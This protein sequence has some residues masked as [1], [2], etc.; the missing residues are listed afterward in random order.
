MTAYKKFV[1]TAA[2]AALVAT[3]VTPA[4]AASKF[5]D[6]STYSADV[7]KEINDLAAAKIINGT[8]ETTFSPAR[9]ITRGQVVKLLGR[10]LVNEGYAKVPADWKTKQRFSDIAVNAT[11]QDL[12]KNAAVVF[13][14]KVFLGSNGKLMSTGKISR[15]NMA[16]VLDRAAKAIN[17]TSF[18]EVVKDE[19]LK[20]N[21]KDLNN[22]KK[23]AREAIAALNALG[24]SNVATFNP[25][26]NVTRA[27]FVSFLH[28]AFYKDASALTIK[29]V[30][31][32]SATELTV[33]LSDTTVHQIKLNSKLPENKE[34]EIRIVVGGKEYKVKVKYVPLAVKSV[35]AKSATELEVVLNDDTKHTVTL[36]EALPEN[37]EQEV[38]FKIDNKEYKVKVKYVPL[39]V[40]SAVAKSATE[41]EVV[42]SDDTKHTVK[43][44][45]A[46]PQNEE[47]EVTFKIANKEYKAKVTYVVEALN[48]LAVTAK[49][50]AQL[51]VKFNQAVK[52][53]G[54]V[55]LR[56][57]DVVDE[58][59]QATVNMSADGKTALVTADTELNG[60]Y[61]VV[62][63]NFKTAAGKVN[64]KYDDVVTVAEDKT[65]PTI[66]G[67]ER[68]F[69]SRVIV[70]FSEPLKTMGKVTVTLSDGKVVNAVP[71]LNGSQVIFDLKDT[72]IPVNTDLLAT[73]VGAADVAGNLISP[74]P[75]NI[76]FQ[77]GKAD[78][79]APAISAVTQTGA[80]TF[81]VQFS[82]AV[83]ALEAKQVNVSKAAVANAVQSVERIS[84]T[85]YKVT[86]ASVL[87]GLTTIA[88]KDVTDLSGEVTTSA[89]TTKTFEVDKVAPKVTSTAVVVKDGQQYLDVNFD[90]NVT[91]DAAKVAVK[92]TYLK[93]GVTYTVDTK[94]K[95]VL[96]AAV[97]NDTVRI[98]L[99]D[100]A[101][102]QANYTVALAFTGITNEA[103]TAAEA[104]ENVTFT[105][106]EDVIENTTKVTVSKIE[107]S[108][109]NNNQIDVTFSHDVDALTATNITNYQIDGVTIEKAVVLSSDL[110]KVTLTLAKDSVKNTGERYIDI[111]NVKAVNSTVAMDAYQQKLDLTE[112]VTP[113]V[114]GIEL[115][116]DNKLELTFTEAV[117]GLTEQSFNVAAGTVAFDGVKTTAEA[118]GATKATVTLKEGDSFKSGTTV[119]VTLNASEAGSVKDSNGNVLDVAQQIL[120]K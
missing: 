77:K 70:T 111:K 87:D 3:A 17:G 109:T 106:G 15:E 69:A 78:G 102:E 73:F 115:V 6:I 51:E 20:G 48:I 34:V 37:K 72:A 32:K 21:V 86:V 92:G 114:S 95:D 64:V 50:A 7:Q 52:T 42:L 74:N 41:L 80:K 75:A 39:T 91:V 40:K 1:A 23:E 105:R 67:T 94:D 71:T 98:K 35:V 16:L 82:E 14:A 54:T 116:G 33:V 113:K 26:N 56:N 55:S 101:Q 36:K 53:A 59:I 88:V 12:V 90:K 28:R 120:I 49:N 29:S 76:A 104:K 62:V 83:H 44:T 103:G 100:F 99:A 19:G 11:D 5:T 8:T 97:D 9:D 24:I 61:V 96:V 107:T 30:V 46:L 117:N 112:N 84:D 81:T 18:S 57:I 27:N 108:K 25:K 2:A 31:V 110:K 45:E 22:A 10:F 79:V 65:A 85:Q 119:Y 63:E 43:L 13:D 93:N 89:S 66:I 4:S 118:S 47:T 60:R 58:T 38:T 68:P